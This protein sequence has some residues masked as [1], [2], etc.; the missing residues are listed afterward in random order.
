MACP[1]S[2]AK[3]SSEPMTAYYN[4]DPCEQNPVTFESKQNN[5]HTYSLKL[6]T[7]K[8]YIYLLNNGSYY[9]P[10]GQGGR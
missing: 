5:F 6:S 3:P 8:H 4:L 9:H 2:D 1:L 10:L 7:T